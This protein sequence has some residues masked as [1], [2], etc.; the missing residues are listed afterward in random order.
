MLEAG[1]TPGDSAAL[2]IMSMN[3]RYEHI[4][5]R[6]HDLTDCG[7]LSVPTAVH[8]ELLLNRERSLLSFV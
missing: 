8:F 7:A 6:T 2:R 5:I 1:S 3:N 4:G